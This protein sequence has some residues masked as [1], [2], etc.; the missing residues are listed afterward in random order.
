MTARSANGWPVLTEPPPTRVV[1]G[2]IVRVSVR[3]G[4]VAEVL[5]EVAARF[6][7]EVERLDL[8]VWDRGAVVPTDDWGW[9]W[10]PV[11]GQ[12]TGYSNHASATAID[13]NATRHPRGASGT[14]TRRQIRAVRRILASTF[15]AA[16][17]RNVVRW[18]EDYQSTVDGMHFEIDA[19]A[20]AV[21]RVAARIRA[22]R[23]PTP[24]PDLLEE[25][26]ATPAERA[27]LVRDIAA[28]TASLLT[29]TLK[30]L[31]A[32]D[33]DG[34]YIRAKGTRAVYQVFDGVRVW[35][36]VAD[37]TAAGRPEVQEVPADDPLLRLRLV[38]Q[39][40]PGE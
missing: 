19:D 9:A 12:T 11:R 18:G 13:L 22:K 36:D 3:P 26:M 37:Y 15:D 16:H 31:L 23:V 10:R 33:S 39:K 32:R 8:I 28:A 34:L 4:D 24:E 20:A 14:F 30:A 21:A 7:A 17:G 35:V 27:A 38:G 25:L 2:T 40:P 1:P 5:L 29:P 6:H